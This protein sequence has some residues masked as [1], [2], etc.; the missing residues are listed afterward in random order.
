V[1]ATASDRDREKS[2]PISDAKPR[3]NTNVLNRK[4]GTA[5]A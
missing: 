5:F 3:A 1:R 2:F 4:C